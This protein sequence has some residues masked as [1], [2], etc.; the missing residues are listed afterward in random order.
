MADNQP[1]QPQDIADFQASTLQNRAILREHN[2]QAVISQSAPEQHVSQSAS[3]F[4]GQVAANAVAEFAVVSARSR[5]LGR[6]NS[7][8]ALDFFLNQ[9]QHR[10]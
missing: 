5:N 7:E 4:S 8:Q 1:I 10:S 2:E 6:M 3:S 9:H